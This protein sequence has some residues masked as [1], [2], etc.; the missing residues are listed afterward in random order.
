MRTEAK[1]IKPDDFY[2]FTGKNLYK[3]LQVEDNESNKVDLFL[4]YIEEVMLDY[5]DM[6]SFMLYD[7]RNDELTPFQKEQLQKALIFQAEYVIRNGNLFT[8]S[9]Y[10]IDKGFIADYDKIQAIAVCRPAENALIKAGIINHK[11][12][13]RIRYWSV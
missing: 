12:R 3:E 1:F 7:L 13:N 9:G 6:K 5:I 11:I 4:M 2:N 8:D 10:D